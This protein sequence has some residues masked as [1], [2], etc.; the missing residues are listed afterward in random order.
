MNLT[1]QVALE[2][3]ARVP[4]LE[5]EAQALALENEAISSS[6]RAAGERSGVELN[7]LAGEMECCE[8]V[9]ARSRKHAR[10]LLVLVVRTAAE[11]TQL[12]Q[13]AGAAQ[14]GQAAAQERVEALGQS[15]VPQASLRSGG[16]HQVARPIQA[17]AATAKEPICGD[18][19]H[20]SR[21]DAWAARTP[22][23]TLVGVQA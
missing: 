8:T 20:E 15:Q 1:L 7:V 16:H 11:V 22:R 5:A 9:L 17:P 23:K 4:R 19:S 2:A 10:R 18:G 12:R 13:T 3:V 14:A 21:E 6:L